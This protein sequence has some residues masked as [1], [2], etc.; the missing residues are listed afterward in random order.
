MVGINSPVLMK[1]ETCSG[2]PGSHGVAGDLIPGPLSSRPA[3]SPLHNCSPAWVHG[4]D[5]GSTGLSEYR[6]TVK[7][8][9]ILPFQD[10]VIARPSSDRELTILLN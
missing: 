10:S 7:R 8:T 6:L 5:T 3:F 1:L 9:Q 2:F 4:V